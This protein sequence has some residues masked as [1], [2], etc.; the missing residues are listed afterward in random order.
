MRAHTIRRVIYRDVVK[1]VP[2]IS[3]VAL[4]RLHG[5]QVSTR[6]TRVRAAGFRTAAPFPTTLALSFFQPLHPIG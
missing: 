2:F 1:G 5:R 3:V 6:S 4:K